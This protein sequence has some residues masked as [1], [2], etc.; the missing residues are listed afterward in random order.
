MEADLEGHLRQERDTCN[1]QFN[2]K[3]NREV[4]ELIIELRT[5][6]NV[7]AELERNLQTQREMYVRENVQLKADL[8]E[9]QTT[10]N[11]MS[12]AYSSMIIIIP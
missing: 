12:L 1:R 6:R 5:E 10:V 9:L 11:Q 7:R 4:G 2:Y 8:A 3:L